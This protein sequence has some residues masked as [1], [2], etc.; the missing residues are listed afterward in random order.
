[1]TTVTISSSALGPD[2]L[3]ILCK[4]VTV[5]FDKNVSVQPLE[6]GSSAAEANTSSFNNP[7]I[8]LNGVN[9]TEATGTLTI[10]HLRTLL[11]LKYNG[12]NAPLLTVTY[13]KSGAKKTLKRWDNTAG[14]IPVILESSNIN[15]DASDSIN[16]Y[17]PSGSI[18]FTETK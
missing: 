13:G 8:V 4:S 9:L 2:P 3:R 10:D 11:T 12:V 18:S 17:L 1:M 14:P 6:N 5:S 7:K 15:I 16:A